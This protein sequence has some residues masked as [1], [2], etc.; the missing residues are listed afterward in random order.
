[1]LI[2][3]MYAHSHVMKIN[4]NDLTQLCLGYRTELWIACAG[5]SIVHSGT[6]DAV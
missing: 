2:K 5:M 3:P 6:G 4:V 1:M